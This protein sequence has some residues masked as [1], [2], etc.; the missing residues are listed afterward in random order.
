MNKALKEESSKPDNF[1][2][3]AGGWAQTTVIHLPD[4]SG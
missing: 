3:T 4:K 1:V 2:A